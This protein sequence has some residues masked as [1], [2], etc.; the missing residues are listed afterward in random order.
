MP[1]QT[2]LELL[3]IRI[4]KRLARGLE[5]LAEVEHVTKITVA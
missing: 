2:A 4:P 1:V 5:A 3:N